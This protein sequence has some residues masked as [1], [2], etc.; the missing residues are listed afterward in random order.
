MNI[1]NQNIEELIA[2]CKKNNQKAQFEIYN[3]YSKAM[4]NVAYR[5]VKD[6][7]FAQDVMQE[8]FLRAFTR[9]NDYKQEVAFGAWLKKIIVN[10]S[11][12]FYK[13]NTAF[14]FEDLSKT[15]Y[16]AEENDSI[17][18]ESID[19]NS[20]KVKQ[21]LDTISELKDNY[22]MVLT[23]FY[24]EGY[25]QEEICDILNIS[26]ANCRTTLSRA[27]ESLRKKLEEI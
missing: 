6:E 3:R 18:S 19:L 4:Y 21:V 9:I 7:H 22:R 25:D 14:Q 16:K 2:L 13:K 8:G 12:D 26:Y 23:L 17:L 10:Y 15:L 24:I 1:T 5:I 20:L 11:I 27:K